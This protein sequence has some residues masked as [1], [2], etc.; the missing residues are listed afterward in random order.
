MLLGVQLH[1]LS[2]SQRNCVLQEVNLTPKTC[3][4]SNKDILIKYRYFHEVQLAIIS[5]QILEA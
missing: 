2:F 4:K 5:I 3:L 1:V